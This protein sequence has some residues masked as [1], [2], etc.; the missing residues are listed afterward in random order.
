MG[1]VDRHGLLWV[2]DHRVGWL[3]PLAVGLTWSGF[4]GL[5]WIAL[6]VIVAWRGARP[7]AASVALVA[8]C[9]WCADLLASAIKLGAA[10]PRPGET[11]AAADP[12]VHTFGSSFPSGH[13]ATSF[14][15]AVV[16][17]SLVPRGVV[18]FL[19]LAAA[20]A[21]SRVYVGVHYPLDVAAGA[22]VGAAIGLGAVALVRSRP[23]LA[24]AL[25][26]SEAR[27]LPG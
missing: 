11:I 14:A 21:Y 5:V 22:L 7:T 6:A 27:P 3:D 10:R 16:L 4:A 26:G 25:Q 2:V 19:L 15:A 1:A 9:V 20:I 12:L 18:W 24:A 13:A 8:A 23:R 17:A